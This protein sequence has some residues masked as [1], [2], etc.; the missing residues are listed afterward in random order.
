MRSPQKLPEAWNNNKH[1]KI[2]TASLL[3][4]NDTEMIAL[5]LG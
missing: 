3:D 4:L 1:L 5:T 2:I